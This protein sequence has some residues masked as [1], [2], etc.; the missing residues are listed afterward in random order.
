[1]R[2][3]FTLMLD[4]L[5]GS[6]PETC[7]IPSVHG[8]Y[9]R[10]AVA[11]NAEWYRSFCRMYMNARRRFPKARTIIR[12]QTTINALR[13]LIVGNYHGIYAERLVAFAHH[14]CSEQVA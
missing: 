4:E 10:V 12:R 5:Q 7:K 14:F 1:M 8:G 3:I 13:R 9:I 11:V 6:Y 2:D